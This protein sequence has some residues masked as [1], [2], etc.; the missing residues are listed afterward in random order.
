M[1]DE[2]V[3]SIAALIAT[4]HLHGVVTDDAALQNFV[5]NDSGELHFID[6]G[7]AIVLR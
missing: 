5:K 4:F 2:D 3:K 7:R 6:F 1:S